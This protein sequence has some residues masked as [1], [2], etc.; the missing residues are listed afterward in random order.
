TAHGRAMAALG[1]P[2]RLAHLALRGKELG[3]GATACDLAALLSERDLFKPS[4]G[5]HP[6]ADLR[7]RLDVL[8]RGDRVGFSHGYAVSRAAVHR[9][10][11]EARH[12]RA[13]LGLGNGDR[14]VDAAGLLLA[15]A[16]PDRIAERRPGSDSLPRAGGER[17]RLRNGRAAALADPQG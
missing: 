9:A 2:P 6:P 5:V 4:G 15:L 16:Y 10:Q 13:R 1:L 8:A 11:K 12:W 3:L 17:Y 14:D 7:L